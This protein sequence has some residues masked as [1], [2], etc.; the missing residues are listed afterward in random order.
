MGRYS[1]TLRTKILKSVSLTV[2]LPSLVL[3]LAFY[4]AW[5]GYVRAR[6]VRDVARS[7][8]AMAGRIG[9]ELAAYDTMLEGLRSDPGLISAFARAAGSGQ[10]GATPAAFSGVMREI[11]ALM[12]D[13][14][15]KAVVRGIGADGRQLFS[16]MGMPAEGDDD[17]LEG[18]WGLYGLM[19]REA[20][21][22]VGYQ[23]LMRYGKVLQADWSLGVAVTDAEGR[24]VGYLSADLALRNSQDLGPGQGDGVTGRFIVTN[25]FD[26]VVAAYDGSAMGAFDRFAIPG[27]DGETSLAGTRYAFARRDTGRHSLSVYGLTS[28]EFIIASFRFGLYTIGVLLLLFSSVFFLVLT[29]SVR[30]MTKPMYDILATMG[31]V[32]QGDFSARLDV[33]SG[34]EFE[35]IAVRLN[36]LIVEMESTVQSLME[37]IELAKTAEMRQLQAQFDPHFLYNTIDTAKWMMRMGEVDKASLML[38]DMAKVLRYSIH[39]R[40]MKPMVSIREDIAAIRTYL[41]IHELSLGER[42]AID[43]DIDEAVLG[44][45]IP[46]LLIQPLVENALVHGIGA[47]GGGRLGIRIRGEASRIEIRV[48]DSGRGF[49]VDP[50]ELARQAEAEGGSGSP[51]MGMALVLRRARLQYGERFSF[52]VGASGEGTSVTLS[53]PRDPGDEACTG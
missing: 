16:T 52:E 49:S 17:P 32:S 26:R 42:L 1:R 20:G 7:T 43:Y 4:V 41:E 44:C 34:D 45:R 14:R 51:G 15:I 25:E 36:G 30:R 27:S 23:R 39:D 10:G 13:R 48:S 37:R 28:I 12:K 47:V 5:N 21:R 38:T 9:A 8:E 19:R 24:L 18:D 35:E 2:A 3:I 50:A 6:I 22:V 31:K 53:I 29:R 11:Y 46:K 33:I 40:Q